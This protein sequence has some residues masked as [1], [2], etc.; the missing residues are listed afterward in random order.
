MFV[1]IFFSKLLCH[2]KKRRIPAWSDRILYKGEGIEQ[3]YYI[4]HPDLLISDH[5]P[6][7]SLFKV[8]VSVGLWIGG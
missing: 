1:E 2:S 4:S 7:S 8:E 3:V 5:K 6:V